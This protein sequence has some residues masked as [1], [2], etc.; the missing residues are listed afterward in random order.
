MTDATHLA[1]IK[2]KYTS[3][4]EEFFNQRIKRKNFRFQLLNPWP[5][6]SLPFVGLLLKFKSEKP[7]DIKSDVTIRYGREEY[8]AGLIKIMIDKII[9]QKA[10]GNVT[11]INLTK[12]KLI[13]KGVNPDKFTAAS[14]DDSAIIQKVRIIAKE[15]GVLV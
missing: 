7:I 13:L 15:M 8:M 11:M 3:L 2:N 14:E 6:D 1:L 10:K 9:T 4:W 5:A 12:T